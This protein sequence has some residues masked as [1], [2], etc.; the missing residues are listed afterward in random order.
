[1]EDTDFKENVVV[2]GN[3]CHKK[4]EGRWGRGITIKLTNNR[5]S[6]AM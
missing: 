2:L 5:D 3:F 4:G 6:K 1:V